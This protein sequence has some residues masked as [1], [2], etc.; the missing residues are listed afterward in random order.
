MVTH[1]IELSGN[2]LKKADSTATLTYAIDP[3]VTYT[4]YT[5]NEITV[6][7]TSSSSI[8][9]GGIIN[10]TFFYAETDNPVTIKFFKGANVIASAF[11]INTSLLITPNTT[12]RFGTVSITNNGASDA[13][14]KIFVAG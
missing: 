9:L 6:V 12:G 10:P 14:V 4:E 13:D 8:N 2:L 7:A 3:K 5:E 1:T 11:P